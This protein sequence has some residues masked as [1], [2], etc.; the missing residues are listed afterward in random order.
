MRGKPNPKSRHN[1][2]LLRKG[3]KQKPNRRHHPNSQHFNISVFCRIK[4]AEQMIIMQ[5]KPNENSISVR[6]TDFD[7]INITHSFFYFIDY[8]EIK[9]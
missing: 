3:E 4:N 6:V 1:L 2:P 7:K 5:P 9:I 8:L